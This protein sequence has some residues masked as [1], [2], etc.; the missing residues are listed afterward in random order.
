VRQ[1]L[2]KQRVLI[3]IAAVL[4]ASG[5]I[6]A[7]ATGALSATSVRDWLDSLGPGAPV[8]FVGAFVL[9]LMVGLPGTA[10]VL[11]AGLAFGPWAG[12]ALAYGGGLLA[13]TVPFVGARALRRDTPPWRPGGAL[14]ARAFD[15]LETHPVTAII[16]LRLILW[17]NAALNYALALSPVRPRDYLLAS[18]IGLAPVVAISMLLIDRLV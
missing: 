11:G 18:A 4:V 17:F 6:Y 9:G 15:K 5:T 16:V 3:A 10:F 13:I 8:L 12:F 2:T 7:W 1:H 14:T